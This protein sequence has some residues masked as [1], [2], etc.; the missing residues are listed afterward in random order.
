M[1]IL[2]P[3][4]TI[5]SLVPTYVTRFS[6]IGP[7]CEDNCCTGWRVSLDKKTFNAYKQSG[8]TELKQRFDEKI[9][10]QRSQSND[11]NYGRI[12]M[13]P[14]SGACPMLDDGL[15]SV[16]KHLG[17]Q[18]LSNTCN[19]YPRH[20]REFSRHIEQTLTLSCPEAAR[21]ALLH[22]D[23]MEFVEAPLLVRT[24]S[25]E[26]TKP[27]R[28][29]TLEMMDEV[30]VFCVQLIHTN[31][32]ELWQKLAILGVF[33]EQLTEH[34]V[35]AGHHNITTLLSNF[36][37]LVEQ[38]QATEALRELAADHAAQAQVFAVLWEN[39]KLARQQSKVQAK[40]NAAVVRGLGADPINGLVTADTLIQCYK[41]GINRLPSVLSNKAP[42]LLENYLLNEMLREFFPFGGLTPYA[43]FLRLVSRFGLIRL[44]LAAQCSQEGS[45]PD[46]DALV[47][48][49]QVFARRFQHDQLF[50][51]RVNEALTN[52]SWGKLEKIYGLLRT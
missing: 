3:T 47:H 21:Q 39:K 5:K 2:H 9:K 26:H 24:E 4:R 17:E 29:L 23:A 33:S 34:L 43:H 15:C 11:G 13:N 40:V 45:E 16:Q 38:G 25:I 31:G 32:L 30:R 10:R 50:A 19:N 14:D 1:N 35:N 36:V 49:V 20:T 6:C 12:E 27:Y 18:Y 7:A 51:S 22:T 8:A 41:S 52:T 37:Q 46:A 44:M 48:T 42:K 28:G